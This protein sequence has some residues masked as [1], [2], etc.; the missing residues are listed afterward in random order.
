MVSLVNVPSMYIRT[1]HINLMNLVNLEICI[2]QE[3][4]YVYT[5]AIN[6]VNLVNL[7]ICIS[8]QLQYVYT[9]AIN[10]V[11]LEI[12]TYFSVAAVCAVYTLWGGGGG[13]GL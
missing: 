8:Q 11:N 6:L 1:F 13:G 4:Q 9:F 5:F 2:S 10:L 3:L 7:E 12:C